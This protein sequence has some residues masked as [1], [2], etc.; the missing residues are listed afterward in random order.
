MST[1]RANT[2]LDGSGG[3]GATINGITPALASQAEAEAGSNNTKLMTPLRV[4][5]ALLA[6]LNVSGSAPTYA[7]RAW[8]TVDNSG[9]LLAGQN[10]AS[11]T[12][13]NPCTVTF[14]TAMPDANYS[15]VVG[16]FGGADFTR[17][18]HIRSKSAGS[19]TIASGSGLQGG[20]WWAVFA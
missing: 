12:G 5:Q 3:N 16:G 10:I 15:V 18:T 13:T 7:C 4:A 1:V 19:F 9:V 8:G 14:A 20:V 2:F 6:E 11:T 17:Y